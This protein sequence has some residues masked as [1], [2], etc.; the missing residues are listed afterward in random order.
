[1]TDTIRALRLAVR[2][3]PCRLNLCPVKP[4]AYFR[5]RYD[6]GTTYACKCGKKTEDVIGDETGYRLGLYERGDGQ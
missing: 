1:M 6:S 2:T 4:V 3:F 5:D